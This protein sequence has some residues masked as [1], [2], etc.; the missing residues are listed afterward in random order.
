VS[1][2]Q[3]HNESAPLLTGS[4]EAFSPLE[5]IQWMAY[6]TGEGVLAFHSARHD[7]PCG[8]VRMHCRD[9]MALSLSADGAAR[10]ASA[11]GGRLGVMLVERGSL[12]LPEL[13][14]ALAFQ[15]LSPAGD[16]RLLGEILLKHRFVSAEELAEGLQALALQCLVEVVSWHSGT[17]TFHA[18]G[19]T[20]PFLPLGERIE[21]LLLRSAHSIDERAGGSP[22]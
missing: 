7:R 18:G 12:S 6:R 13:R 20:P 21:R 11:G 10:S 2:E 17:F 14:Y 4:L 22:G 16:H 15:R 1:R 19:L 5:V 8:S 3:P 9:G